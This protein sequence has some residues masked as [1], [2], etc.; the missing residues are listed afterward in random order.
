LITRTENGFPAMPIRK[1]H[2]K[3]D[4]V[5]FD[6]D[7]TLMDTRAATMETLHRTLARLGIEPVE[8]PPAGYLHALTV[9]GMLRAVG[10]REQHLLKLACKEF[11]KRYRV[12]AM[13]CSHLFPGV[14][15]IL[16]TLKHLGFRMAVAT[17]EFRC[18]LDRFI[19]EF[20]LDDFFRFTVC[21]DEVALAKP[22]PEMA[23]TALRHLGSSPDTALMVGDSHLDIQMGRS[24]GLMTCAVTHGCTPGRSLVESAPDF[25]IDAFHDLAAVL[26]L[27]IAGPALPGSPA[28]SSA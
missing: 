16:E 13:V 11:A 4:A 19:R 23:M 22:D 28:N 3:I 18:N 6:F 25:F 1:S 5:I 8:S 24:A 27:P 9:D 7:G 21:A 15:E 14:I 10:V 26:E 17:N 12:D 2:S 20:G